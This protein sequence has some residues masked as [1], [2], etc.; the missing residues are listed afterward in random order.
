M[1][2]IGG[3]AV[4][5]GVMM[6]SPSMFAVAVR[7]EKGRIV[8]KKEKL[9]SVASRLRF[10]RLPFFRGMLALYESLAL[11]FKALFWSAGA[12]SDEQ[13]KFSKKDF[14]IA[15]FFALFFAVAM[16]IIIPF[17][18][19]AFLTKENSFLFNLV[20]GLI[21]IAFFVAYIAAISL[22]KDVRVMFQYHGAEHK[23]VNAFEA[24]EELSV[25][26][27]RKHSTVHMRCGTSF[28]I[29]VFIIAVFVFS[30]VPSDDWAVR[31]LSRVVLLPV[32]VG[33][34]YEFLKLSSR[35]RK[36]GVVRLL[37]LPGLLLQGMTT[38]EPDDRQLEVSI[39]ALKALL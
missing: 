13:D 5:E 27:V 32:I 2:E 22:M 30:V 15:V 34:S 33:A 26:N 23:A 1:A 18:L 21:R 20:D 37:F 28:L 36:F 11:G 16:F 39:A 12:A 6:R 17:Y 31:I 9:D 35:F 10:F 25:M 4:V 24:G 14:F 19:T 38:K 8:V 3:Q 7:D 29:I